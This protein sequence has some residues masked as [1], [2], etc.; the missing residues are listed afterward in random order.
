VGA[1]GREAGGHRAGKH[2]AAADHY[3][4]VTRERE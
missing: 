1:G 3:G 2:A 4:D